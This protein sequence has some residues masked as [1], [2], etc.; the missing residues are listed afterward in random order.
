MRLP[1][2]G[3]PPLSW[4]PRAGGRSFETHHGFLAVRR[5]VRVPVA[6]APL[7]RWCRVGGRTFSYADADADA[8]D[9]CAP[10]REIQLGQ[11]FLL[12]DAN[13]ADPLAF[14]LHSPV[15]GLRVRQN[16]YTKYIYI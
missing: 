9:A 6:A 3:V 11:A 5:N 7:R 4:V 8:D 2:R 10:V 16:T 13:K 14:E 1:V 12:T 15:D